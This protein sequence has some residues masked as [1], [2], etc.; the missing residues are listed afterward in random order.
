MRTAENEGDDMV[1]DTIPRRQWLSAYAANA[2]SQDL[3]EVNVLHDTVGEPVGR[4]ETASTAG[5]GQ[6]SSVLCVF[7][8]PSAFGFRSLFRVLTSPPPSGIAIG[9]PGL[10]CRWMTKAVCSGIRDFR[11]AFLRVVL[12]IKLFDTVRVVQP[13]NAGALV[14]TGLFLGRSS[15]R[16]IVTRDCV[17]EWRPQ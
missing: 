14:V 4:Q 17:T 13:P 2:R 16:A 3:I 1:T 5:R 12:T 8:C 9:D 10:L 15:H 6:V 11:A 7:P